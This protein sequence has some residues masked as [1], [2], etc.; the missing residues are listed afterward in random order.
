MI[1]I[2]L[3]KHI[4]TQCGKAFEARKEYAYKIIKDYDRDSY[5]WFCSYKCIQTYRKQIKPRQKTPSEKEQLIL[6]L[7]SKGVRQY[8]IAQRAGVSKQTVY[9]VKKKWEEIYA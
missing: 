6:D 3:Y 1:N 8:E 5:F 4:C 2:G 9:K 7:L